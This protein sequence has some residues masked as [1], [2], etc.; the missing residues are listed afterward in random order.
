M[1]DEEFDELF[2]SWQDRAERAW[3]ED[4]EPESHEQEES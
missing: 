3:C 4:N 2:E 1:T